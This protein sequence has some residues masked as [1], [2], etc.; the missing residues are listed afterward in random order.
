MG[1]NEGNNKRSQKAT[2]VLGMPWAPSH[3]ILQPP[4]VETGIVIISTFHR[5]ELVFTKLLELAKGPRRHRSDTKVRAHRP[6]GLPCFFPILCWT[7]TLFEHSG[8][9]E[10]LAVVTKFRVH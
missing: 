4:R 6:I 2:T 5:G 8:K 3:L 10:L 9:S 1:D 7:M